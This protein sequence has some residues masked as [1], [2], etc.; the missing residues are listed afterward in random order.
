MWTDKLSSLGIIRYSTYSESKSAIVERFNR[1]MK[2][3]MFRLFTQ[4]GDQKWIPI[5]G[6]L[7]K[8]YNNRVHSS[9]GMTPAQKMLTRAEKRTRVDERQVFNRTASFEL[10]NH[11][12]VSRQKGVF[13]KGYTWGWSKVNIDSYYERISAKS[14][15]VLRKQINRKAIYKKTRGV[16]YI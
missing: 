2:T 3:N 8:T 16:N 12:R 7:V 9:I 14:M 11:V 6:L 1:T 13:E 15:R 4:R 10:G 5:L